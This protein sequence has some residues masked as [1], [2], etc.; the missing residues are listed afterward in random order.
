MTTRS[1][2]SCQGKHYRCIVCFESVDRE[3][4]RRSEGATVCVVDLEK[5]YDIVPR[6]EVW[7]CMRK[8]GLAEMTVQQR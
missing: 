4:Q 8:S 5:A 3:V 2:V 7:Y 6:E 1:T